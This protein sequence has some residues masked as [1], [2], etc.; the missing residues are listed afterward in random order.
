M[1]MSVVKS[2]HGVQGLSSQNVIQLA[3]ELD[4]AVPAL[5][6]SAPMPLGFSEAWEDAKDQLVKAVGENK[7]DSQ[8]KMASLVGKRGLRANWFLTWM[9]TSKRVWGVFAGTMITCGLLG[10]LVGV[11]LH[12]GEGVGVM[13]SG[14]AA[15]GFFI[16]APAGILSLMVLTTMMDSRDN[17]L[18]KPI[19]DVFGS[20][21]YEQRVIEW[22]KERYG[23]IIPAGA[24]VEPTGRVSKD[25]AY[26]GVKDG[27]NVY[28]FET[29]SGWVIGHRDGTELPILI[30]QKKLVNA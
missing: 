22:A 23:V 9:N 2:E 29:D 21:G 1:S 28:C 19:R 27:E 5:N 12:A 26:L 15:A 7:D 30:E 3:S 20:A 11:G 13:I 24:W 25:I 18:L 8:L 10:S 16:G 4:V 6:P 14:A 17:M